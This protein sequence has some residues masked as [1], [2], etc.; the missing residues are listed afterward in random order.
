MRVFG[1][2][3]ILI[4][5]SILISCCSLKAEEGKTV[6]I[7]LTG[8]REILIPVGRDIE[9]KHVGDV[10]CFTDDGVDYELPIG[11][12]ERISV[13]GDI[14]GVEDIETAPDDLWFIYDTTGKLWRQGKGEIT[15]DS[16]PGAEAYI[17]R[18]GA[19]SYKIY[20]RK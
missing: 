13:K 19:Y 16:L 15:F 1:R 7:S 8:N 11:D 9:I 10:L 18:I 3:V 2:S 4:A 14:N 12:L 5:F 20:K 6:C 17:V